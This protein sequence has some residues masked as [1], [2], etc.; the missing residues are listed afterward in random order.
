[1]A[2]VT[3]PQQAEVIVV[4]SGFGGAVAAAR[5][6]QAG[7]WGGGS[8][9]YAN[10]FARPFDQ[11]LEDRWPL[12]MRRGALDPYYD[13]AAHMLEVTPTTDDPR[14]GGPAP[15]TAL[16]EDFMARSN[17]PE[18]TARPNLAV[19][20]GDPDQW[21]PNIHGVPRRGCAFVGECVLGCN[22]GAKNTLDTKLSGG[23]RVGR[24]AGRHRRAGRPDR[25]AG[26]WLCRDRLDTH[27]SAGRDP[28]VG[29]AQGRAGCRHGRHDRD[30]AAGS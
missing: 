11:M 22:H 1:M 26:R 2:P 19:T 12:H 25:A 17:I 10:V 5:F 29:R 16:I 14:T 18:A 24:R 30:A 3:D 7:G 28:R 23:G 20:F 13:L 15:R 8:L 4:G 6:A 9:A 27:G 21:R